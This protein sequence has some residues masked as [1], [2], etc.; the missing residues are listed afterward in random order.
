MLKTTSEKDNRYQKY[1][2]LY[3][4]IN[5]MVPTKLIVQD[6]NQNSTIIIEYNEIELN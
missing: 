3:I 5:N 4:D 2:V 6:Y 1:K